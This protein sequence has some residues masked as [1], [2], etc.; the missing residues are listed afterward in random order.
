MG[1]GKSQHTL[2]LI[3][4]A[5]EILAEI[6]PASIRAVCYR[7]FTLNMISSMKKSETNKV[8]T[9]LT[10]ARENGVIPW[11]WI[12]DETRAP[13]RVS[14][15]E[16]PSDYVELVKVAYR[17][18]R[19]VDQPDWVEVW[20]E[21]GT[22]R[23]TLASVLESYGVT[24]RVMHGYGSATAI[25][26]AATESLDSKK[27]LTVFYVGDWDPSGL[28]MSEVDLPRRLCDYGGDVELVRL[29]LT[30]DDCRVDSLPSFGTDTKKRDPRYRWYLDRYGHRC[31]E[32]DALNPVVLRD[33]VSQAIDD[34]LDHDAW[35][36]A[37]VV[38]RAERDSLT[39]ILA[40][41]PGI[42]GQATKY[43]S[44]HDGNADG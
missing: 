35:D 9:Q 1:R 21:K 15:W 43:Q 3:D 19:W 37:E 22:I 41:W 36:R 20:S 5:W 42:S 29:A 26:Q 39:S 7:L 16:N 30:D 12:V 25:N 33:R 2:D 10:W 18:D 17:R 44:K 28:H 13:E 27:T 40:T 34:R 32:L 23:G 14:A 31:W 8:S 11:K 6:H 4:A 24:F 38:E